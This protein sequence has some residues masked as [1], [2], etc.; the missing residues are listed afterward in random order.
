MSNYQSCLG[1]LGTGILLRGQSI[2]KCSWCLGQGIVG[3]DTNNLYKTRMSTI[4]QERL[5]ENDRLNDT[6]ATA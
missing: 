5:E 4:I 3:V 2:G 6:H 1:C